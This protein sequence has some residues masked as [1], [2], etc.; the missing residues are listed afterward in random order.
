MKPGDC[1]LQ[2]NFVGDLSTPT[3]RDV[4][5][6]IVEPGEN[7]L[8]EPHPVGS[9][10]HNIVVEGRALVGLIDEAVELGVETIFCYPADQNIYLELWKQAQ[11]KR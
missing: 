2:S 1:Q 9:V 8:S 6:L 11:Q 5:L 3:R 10:E 7:R 4:Y